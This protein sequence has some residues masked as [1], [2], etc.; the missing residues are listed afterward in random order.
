MQSLGVVYKMKLNKLWLVVV[1]FAVMAMPA[2][3]VTLDDARQYL[4]YN[5]SLD[6]GSGNGFDGTANG[7]A[8][9]TGSYFILGNGSLDCGSSNSD[10]VD[11]P[12]AT[13]SGDSTGSF[14]LWMYP[15][16]AG[17]NQMFLSAATAGSTSNRMRLMYDTNDKIQLNINDGSWDSFTS[18]DT[19]SPNAWHHIVVTHDGTNSR[20]YINGSLQSNTG[21]NTWFDDISINTYRHCQRAYAT[22]HYFGGFLDDVAY[23]ERALNQS[24]IDAL[25]NSGTGFN[26]YAAPAA[27]SFNITAANAETAAAINTFNVTLNGTTF[28]T[29]NGTI[30]VPTSGFYTTVVQSPGFIPV[31]TSKTYAPGSSTQWNLT[32]VLRNVTVTA[33]DQDG[34]SLSNFNVSIDGTP[35]NVAGTSDVFE[36]DRTI[37]HNFTFSKTD[38]YGDVQTNVNVTTN[39]QGS[40]TYAI[41]N[42]T[43]TAQDET[44]ASLSNFNVTI[45]ATTYNIPGASGDIELDS[46][47]LFN[48]TWSKTNYISFTGTNLNANNSQVGNLT[49]FFHITVFTNVT[50]TNGTAGTT[51]NSDAYHSYDGSFSDLSGN[52]FPGTP[53]GSTAIDSTVFKVGNGSMVTTTGSGQYLNM[54]NFSSTLAADNAG[55][56][57]MWVYPH[58][59]GLTQY[60]MGVAQAGDASNRFRFLTLGGQFQVSMRAGSGTPAYEYSAGSYTANN[61]YHLVLTQSGVSGNKFYING[62]NVQNDSNNAWFNDMVG[63]DTV[64]IGA[65]AFSDTDSFDGNIDEWGY[66]DYALTPAQVAELYNNGT[67]FNPYSGTAGNGTSVFST[68]DEYYVNW[69]GSSYYPQSDNK[70]YLPVRFTLENFTVNPTTPEFKQAVFN[71]Y[72]TTTHLNLTFNNSHAVTATNR[73]NSAAILNFTVETPTQNYTSING[74]A[75]LQN[76][77]GVINFT[78]SATDFFN[79]VKRNIDVTNGSS[80]ALMHQVE[81]RFNGSQ[82]FT[83][84]AIADGNVTIGATTNAFNETFYLNAGTYTATYTSSNDEANPINFTYT[85]LTNTTSTITNITNANL[86][87]TGINAVDGTPITFFT[88]SVTNDTLT[89]SLNQTKSSPHLY[90]L[91]QNVTYNVVFDNSS[92]ALEDVNLTLLNRSTS[93]QFTVFTTNSFNISI[94]DEQNASHITDTN[95]TIEFIGSYQSYNYT[96]VDGELYADLIVPDLYQIRY[97]YINESGATNYGLHRQYFHQLTN[98]TH[99]PLDFYALK[100]DASTRV[101]INVQNSDTLQRQEG[102]YVL[103]Q[104]F[105][106][107]NNSYNTVAMYETDSQGNAYFDVELQDELYRFVLQSPFGTTLRTTTPS[108]LEETSYIIYTGDTQTTFA[109]PIGLGDINATFDWDNSTETLTVTYSDPENIY[110]TYTLNLYEEGVYTNTLINTSSATTSS[111]TLVVSYAFQNDTEYIGTMTVSNSP[112]IVAASFRISDFTAGMPLANLSLFLVSILFVIMTFISAFSLYSVVLGAVALIAASMMGLLTFSGPVVGMIVFGA[113]MLAIVLEWRRG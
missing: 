86:S 40:L 47:E 67:G 24:E 103:L 17:N 26:P 93:Y 98:R 55:S 68:T 53:A 46:R 52:G 32:S 94:L 50:T 43:F 63:I 54:N 78:V 69:N 113:I 57:A 76:D 23:Y 62:V 33:I 102:V 66:W 16:V 30:I 14:S 31:T 34:A 65:R 100:D 44:Y 75:F 3:A 11:F 1:L 35:H 4:G 70:T 21:G 15:D 89:I 13:I 91:I 72:N 22:T 61:W 59:S 96:Y 41:V 58:S 108:Y 48:A 42:T 92:F 71:N 49:E 105:Y 83:G 79:A 104:R 51:N 106:L 112:A 28:T 84:N 110:G 29:T 85:A 12:T 101:T 2:M 88:T 38:Y 19:I 8:A 36:L 87:I 74:T 56:I 82:R 97:E 77:T 20:M 109:N 111:G 10:Y 81:V 73:F 25:Y 9:V 45:G 18:D 7:A 95:F 99:N 60:I 80:N 107:A 64:R 39:V 90:N 6:D 37:L 27:S 5:S